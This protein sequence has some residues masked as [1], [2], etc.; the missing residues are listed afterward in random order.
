MKVVFR[1]DAS[2]HIGS[3][4]VVRCLTLADELARR[5]AHCL[6]V[7]RPLPGHMIDYIRGRGYEVMVLPY[8][9][10]DSAESTIKSGT[11][12]EHLLGVHWAI[13]AEQTKS[14]LSSADTDWLI[15]DHYAID[16]RWEIDLEPKFGKLLAIDD[17]ANRPHIADVL[18]DQNYNDR[19]RYLGLVP[20]DSVLLLGPDY[21]LI[22]PEYA[23]FRAQRPE[24]A[25]SVKKRVFVYFGGSDSNDL[26][27][28]T[29]EALSYPEVINLDVDVV[30]GANYLYFERLN[31]LAL[32]RGRTRIHEPRLHLADLMS[33]ADIAVG[34]G[35]VTN[36]ERI[37]IGLP[38]LVVTLADNQIPISRIL[39]ELGVIDLIGQSVSIDVEAIRQAL[40]VE[41]RTGR[42]RSK[43]M[44]ALALCDGLGVQRVAEVLLTS[45]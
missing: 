25:D 20:R 36:W 40:Q 7:C 6:F 44:E 35:G 28:K 23:E 26:T 33:Q 38:S 30:V 18:L 32:S 4:H 27:G 13:D 37:C 8:T 45:R 16:S 19:N 42:I 2:M 12:Y 5:N 41:I 14:L 29:I 17:I 34:A 31:S 43:R 24:L 15:V 3:G 22:R 39:H 21:A 11:S 9:E 10:A 1:T